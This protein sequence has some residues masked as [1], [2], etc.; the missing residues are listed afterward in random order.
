MFLKLVQKANLSSLLSEATE[1]GMT[2]FVPKDEVFQEVADWLSEKSKSELEDIIKSHIVPDVL[3]C[4]GI[5]KAEWP[6]ARTIATLNKNALTLNRDRR[7]KVQNAGIT[8]CDVVAKNGI[9]HEVNDI[10][11]INRPVQNTQQ[12]QNNFYGSFFNNPNLFKSPFGSPF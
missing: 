6:F 8:K 11:T 12:P 10:I 4:A 5:V 3:C 7:P 9:I 1:D 2:L